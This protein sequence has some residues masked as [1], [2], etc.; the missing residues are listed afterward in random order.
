MKLTIHTYNLKLEHTFAISREARNVQETLIVT[1]EDQGFVGYGE[2]TSSSYYGETRIG[3]AAI[4]EGLKQVVEA[5]SF[6]TPELFWNYMHPFLRKFPF[7]LSALDSAAHDLYGKKKNLPLYKLWGLKIDKLPISTY[8][9]GID[10]IENM[11]D[12]LKAKPWP[13]YKIKLGTKQ[14]IEIVKALRKHTD[15][16]FRIDANCAW[17]PVET[18]DTSFVLKDLG[19]EFIEQP[20]PREMGLRGHKKVLKHGALP[21]IADE[22][23]RGAEDLADCVRRFHGI[24]IKLVKCGGLTPALK[25]IKQARQLGL[26]IMIGCMTE[27]S[28]GISA[29]AQ[30]LPLVDYADLDGAILLKKDIAKGVTLENGVVSYSGGAGIGAELL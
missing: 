26:K 19:V 12:K 3:M 20:L 23:F 1:L 8:T 28:I 27:S 10:S 11:V 30:L 25:I 13:I 2:A 24:N 21:I 22:S 15:A 17:T 4:L 18:V 14:D 6:D 29:A 9:I 7:V 5:Y 16:P